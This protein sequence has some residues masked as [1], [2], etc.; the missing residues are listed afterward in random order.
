MHS[1]DSWEWRHACVDGGVWEYSPAGNWTRDYRVTG[2]DTN[3]FTTRDWIWSTVQTNISEVVLPNSF[4]RLCSMLLLLSLIIHRCFSVCMRA[5]AWSSEKN[6]SRLDKENL[7]HGV[8]LGRPGIECKKKHPFREV[9]V[10][11]HY[12]FDQSPLSRKRLR[13]KPRRG[14]NTHGARVGLSCMGSKGNV[15]PNALYFYITWTSTTT[16]TGQ[17]QQCGI[18]AWKRRGR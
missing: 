2:G 7:V 13:Q 17:W 18:N 6:L 16:S 9:R 14:S 10:T 8:N 1:D 3:H 11:S 4:E 15:K 5:L 12:L